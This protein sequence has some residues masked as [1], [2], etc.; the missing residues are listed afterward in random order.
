M[1]RPS[2]TGLGFAIAGGVPTDLGH[3]LHLEPGRDHQPGRRRLMAVVEPL[4]PT[5]RGLEVAEAALAALREGFWGAA[6]QPLPLALG[7]AFAAAN[8]AV[9]D[10]NRLAPGEGRDRRVGVGA[11]AIAVEG[12]QLVLA[13]VPPSQAILVQE[14]RVYAFPELASWDGRFTALHHR[15]EPDPEPLGRRECANP[16]LYRTLAAPDDLVVLCASAL[17]MSLVRSDE[18][19]GRLSPHASFEALLQAGDP[20]AVAARLGRIA[21]AHDLGHAH[22][23]C[24]TIGRLHC[25][26][27]ALAREQLARLALACGISTTAKPRP[28]RVAG[29]H[30]RR[31]GRTPATGIPGGAPS[32]GR[33]RRSYTRLGVPLGGDDEPDPGGTEGRRDGRGRTRARR[34]PSVSPSPRPPRP[35]HVRDRSGARP[36]P[37]VVT[38]RWRSREVQSE[39]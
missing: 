37:S 17:P 39:S 4:D 9:R 36:A 22:A 10:E 35:L 3:V 33:R 5:A 26:D 18:D 1:P 21:E 13:Q 23:A 8:A 25:L 7:E 34:R 30:G 32:A 38:G 29:V 12:R 27:I 15:I 6:G 14:G 24:C 31:R 19:S 16:E 28:P 20:E 11:T 2:A